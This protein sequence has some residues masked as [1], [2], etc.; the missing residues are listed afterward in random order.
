MGIPF[1]N[2][3][4]QLKIEKDDEGDEEH[5]Y[6][7]T[8]GYYLKTKI[9]P[10]KYINETFEE[11]VENEW[12]Q[13]AVYNGFD[14]NLGPELI[15]WEGRFKRLHQ[16]DYKKENKKSKNDKY[17][18]GLSKEDLAENEKRKQLNKQRKKDE[19]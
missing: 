12:F 6:K 19:A 10:N 13:G 18:K 11:I 15:R 4:K 9:D 3:L 14:L 1:D 16:K 2:D 7:I 5:Q 17:A 8:C